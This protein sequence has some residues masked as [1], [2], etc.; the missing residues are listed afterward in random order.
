MFIS[1]QS[2][3]IMKWRFFY[4]KSLRYFGKLPP[5][6]KV[7]YRKGVMLPL[8]AQRPSPQ[9][10]L[11]STTSSNSSLAQGGQRSQVSQ[12]SFNHQLKKN[13]K[14]HPED[15]EQGFTEHKCFC[16]CNI[17]VLKKRVGKLQFGAPK[18]ALT[19]AFTKANTKKVCADTH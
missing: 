10:L 1:L 18:H 17:E 4:S 16:F 9:G 5:K 19:F 2:M 6:Y 14:F 3:E 13:P 15:K 12:F 7:V 11:H 8:A